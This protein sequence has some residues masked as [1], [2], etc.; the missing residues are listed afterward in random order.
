[1]QHQKPTYIRKGKTIRNVETGETETL[2]S[3]SAAK[4]R[5]R[6]IQAKEPPMGNGYLR[7]E[8]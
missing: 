1:M 6:E 3:I 7:V 2:K 8:S 4:R 5:S